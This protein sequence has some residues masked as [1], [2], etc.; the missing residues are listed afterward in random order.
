MRNDTG[1]ATGVHKDHINVMSIEFYH[2]T[3]SGCQEILSYKGVSLYDVYTRQVKLKLAG[4]LRC[5]LR[6]KDF[7]SKRRKK[8][9]L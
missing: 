1:M 3:K 8:L 4:V 6:I 9:K 5:A 7:N 2:D